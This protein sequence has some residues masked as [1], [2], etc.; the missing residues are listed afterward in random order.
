[1]VHWKTFVPKPK[2]VIDVVG[3]SEFVIVPE[4][5]TNVQAPVPTTAAFAFI[6]V[7]GDEI[8]SV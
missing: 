6:V 5:E 8:Q 3:E 4:P 2:P 7:V 1:M